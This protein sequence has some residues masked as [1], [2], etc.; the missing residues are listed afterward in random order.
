MG[1]GTLAG[2]TRL[3]RRAASARKSLAQRLPPKLPMAGNEHREAF[4]GKELAVEACRSREAV[5]KGW[6]DHVFPGEGKGFDSA[7]GKTFTGSQ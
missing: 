4:G 1:M 7:R 5:L 2:L 6:D 3:K